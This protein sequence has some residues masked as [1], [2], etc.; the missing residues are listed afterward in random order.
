[1]SASQSNSA[2]HWRFLT[3]DAVLLVTFD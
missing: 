1:L 3:L 2:T